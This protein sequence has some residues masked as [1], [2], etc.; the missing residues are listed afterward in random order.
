MSGQPSL[1]PSNKVTH[2]SKCT[3]YTYVTVCIGKF[4]QKLVNELANRIL[5]TIT[6]FFFKELKSYDNS[7][8]MDAEHP[9]HPIPLHSS[10]PCK[11]LTWNVDVGERVRKGSLLC[12]Y[13]QDVGDCDPM[14]GRLQLKSSVVG[15]VKEVLV[16]AGEMV[17]P[18]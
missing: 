18:G 8:P 16:Q 7:Y 15:V 3:Y 6:T 2:H 9:I 14:E 4:P 13:T 12:V 11:L 17:P 10:I 5:F 1:L